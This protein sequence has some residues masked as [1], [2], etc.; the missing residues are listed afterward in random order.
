[1]RVVSNGLLL[2]S[3]G[4]EFWDA[5]RSADC[6]LVLSLYPTGLDYGALVALAQVHGVK[7]G[8][9][10][11]VAEGGAVSYFLRTP[12]D[13]EGLQDRMASFNRCPLGGVCL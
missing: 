10:G 4:P 8:I 9:S 6:K 1:M 13:E 11:G 2:K 3:M 5:M 12:L 7:T